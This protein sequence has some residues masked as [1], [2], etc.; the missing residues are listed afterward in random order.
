MS[1]Q[2]IED[3]IKAAA[4]LADAEHVDEAAEMASRVLAYDPD[5][6]KALFIIGSVM[7][8]VGR[9]VQAQQ[10]LR[11]VCELKPQ[12]AQGW[13][14]LSISCAEMHRYEEAIRYAEKAVKFKKEARTY[15]D[16]SFA[17]TT[18]G[19]W[20]KGREYAKLSLHLDPEFKD[21]RFHLANCDLAEQNWAA[22]W[23]GFKTSEGTKWRKQYSY[24]NTVEWQGE[25]D[26]VVMVTGEQG[27]GDEVMAAG[28]IPD[29]IK[30]CRQFIF[31]CDDR[32]QVL[33]ARS[34]PQAIVV[35]TRHSKTVALPVAPTHHKSLFGL[36]ELF[37]NSNESFPRRPYLLPNESYRQMFKTLFGKRRTIG[38]AWSG[39][40]PRTGSVERSAGLS[41]FLPLL[42]EESDALFVSLQYKD[43]AAEVSAFEDKTGCKVLRLPWVAQNKDVDLLAA[44]IASLDEVVGVHT[45]SLHLSSALGVPTTTLTHRGSGW[46]YAPDQ[47]LW[48]PPTTQLWKKDR[49]ESWR[50]C[51]GHLTRA[52]RERR[53]EAA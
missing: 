7:L 4:D 36:A 18:A 13:G 51:I 29:A 26:A 11:R 2:Q 16:A 40:F 33:F 41:A 30:G 8:K 45:A 31:D 42:R 21:A 12:A 46:R 19:N 43:D 25:P 10:F 27:M 5:N 20:A 24:G 15:G 37:R 52:R 22:G 17:H 32:A 23:Q 35:P 3:W 49:G 28:M 34:F 47:M 39:G 9:N 1:Q 44:L 48:Y 14:Q 53:Q 6:H 38:L 50:D